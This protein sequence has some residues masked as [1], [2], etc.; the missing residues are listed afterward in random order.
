MTV[1]GT[2]GPDLVRTPGLDAEEHKRGPRSPEKR[3]GDGL[4]RALSGIA[5]R[6]NRGEFPRPVPHERVGPCRARS[7]LAV[8]EPEVALL[9][10]AS[11]KEFASCLRARG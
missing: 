6:G 10:R 11:G 4:R 3:C 9:D 2:M 1:G 7:Q 5:L 8:D